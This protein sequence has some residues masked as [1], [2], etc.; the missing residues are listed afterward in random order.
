MCV[1]PVTFPWGTSTTTFAEQA[2]ELAFGCFKI[3]QL[4]AL[5]RQHQLAAPK[6]AAIPRRAKY[7]FSCRLTDQP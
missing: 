4:L 2:D 1:P 7:T 5:V 3:R 6:L